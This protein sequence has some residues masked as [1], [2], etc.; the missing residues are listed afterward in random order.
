MLPMSS[1]LAGRLPIRG[2]GYR[3]TRLARTPKMPPAIAIRAITGKVRD[4]GAKVATTAMRAIGG[5]A[6]IRTCVNFITA[7]SQPNLDRTAP[8]F[9]NTKDEHFT[10]AERE[11]K[12]ASVE[13]QCNAPFVVSPDRDG[14]RDGTHFGLDRFELS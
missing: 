10:V 8:G 14:R 6:I 7:K 9:C 1:W 5:A 4:S 11:L 13:R 12:R 2:Q 3:K